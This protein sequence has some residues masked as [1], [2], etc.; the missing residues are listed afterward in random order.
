MKKTKFKTRLLIEDRPQVLNF[1]SNEEQSPFGKDMIT[2][3]LAKQR[4]QFMAEMGKEPKCLYLRKE[5]LSELIKELSEQPHFPV[6][7]DEKLK[8]MYLYGAKV[9]P[10]STTRFAL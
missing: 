8:D 1:E 3:R 4:Y 2:E 9:I 5:D 7:E 6:S 10:S